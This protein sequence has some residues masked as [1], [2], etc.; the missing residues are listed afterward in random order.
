LLQFGAPRWGLA[1][2][3]PWYALIGATTTFAVG[4]LVAFASPPQGAAS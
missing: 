2:A 3:W 1:V 4:C